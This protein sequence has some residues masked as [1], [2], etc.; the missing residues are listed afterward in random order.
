MKQNY[1]FVFI[2]LATLSIVNAIPH[3]LHKRDTTFGACLTGS[4]N[5]I[6]VSVQPDPPPVTG[7]IIFTIS[8]ALKTGSISAGSKLVFNAIDVNGDPF[9]YPLTYDICGLPEVTCPTDTFSITRK[10]EVK[11][12]T[13]TYSVIIQLFS[14]SGQVLACS[15]GTVTGN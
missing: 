11:K 8:G 9:A 13:P 14:A 12:F 2:L 4:P 1:I 6:K 10:I 7:V 15:I 3:Q 5:L